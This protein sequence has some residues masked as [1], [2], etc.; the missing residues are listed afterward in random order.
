METPRRDRRRSLV[1]GAV[2]VDAAARGLAGRE[3]D[4]LSLTWE[5]RRWTR[6][7]LR[8]TAG[9]DVA[10]ALP[11][12]SVLRDGEVIAVAEDWYLAVEARPEPVLA[13]LPRDR[14]ESVRVAFEAGNRHVALAFDGATM[15]IR[16]EAGMA[17]L[18]TRLG[19][20]CRR[21]EAVFEPLAVGPA[22]GHRHA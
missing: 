18:L 1:I 21:T 17:H 5:E 19:I 4:T 9:R 22:P 6:K 13:V 8:T 14:H 2:D 12:G 15:L 3:R 11:T 20:A 16:D 10:L 7:R